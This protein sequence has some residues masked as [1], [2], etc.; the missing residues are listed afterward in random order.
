MLLAADFVIAVLVFLVVGELRF[1]DAKWTTVWRALDIDAVVGAVLYAAAW[2]TILW[3]LGLYA[4]RV[5][6][7]LAG[8]LNEILVGSLLM[9]FGTMT[10]L[11]LVKLDVSRLFLG[12]VFVGPPLITMASRLALRSFFDWLRS[13]GYNRCYMVVIGTG[14]EAQSFADTIERHHELGIQI[15]GHLRGP[16]EDH[17]VVTRPILGDV[18]DL[19][20]VFHERVVDEVAL[21]A[22][23]GADDAEWAQPIIRLAVIPGHVVDEHGHR[24]SSIEC[25]V[26]AIAVV[27]VDEAGQGIEPRLVGVVA[28]DVGPLREERLVEALRLAIRL[29]PERPGP[30]VPGADLAD[31]CGERARDGVVPGVV[32]QDPLDPHAVAGEEGRRIEQEAGTGR[33]A[34]VGKRRH[35]GDPAHV[36]DGD[37]EV[38]VA[39]AGTRRAGHPSTEPMATTIRDPAELLDVDVEQLAGALPDIADRDARWT[40]LVAQPGQSVASQDIADGRAWHAHDAGQ[41]MGTEALGMAGGEDLVDLSLR[42][43]PGRVVWPRSPVLQASHSLG[44]EPAQPLPGRLPAD[45]DH[46][47]GVG[48]GHPVDDD[49][50]HQELSAEDRQLRPTMCHESLPSVVSWIPTPSLGRLS[51]V[52]N[53]FGNHI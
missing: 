52:N 2:V 1:G 23:V 45:P 49:P 22:G 35:V 38:V 53:L 13:R 33:A 42:Q 8:E 25:A 32:G 29:R 16:D 36:V 48:H 46:V 44:L 40:I 6:W 43:R 27:S 20:R 10:F 39:G 18:S 21:C 17:G 24:R 28:S 47:R 50:I 37:M 31:R 11:Y 19:G 41:A 15:I 7:S 12:V 30:L 26:R 5:R 34:L 4:F 9:A 14:E 3:A 51:F